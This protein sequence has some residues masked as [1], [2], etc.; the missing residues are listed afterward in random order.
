MYM[1]MEMLYVFLSVKQ[2]HLH[3]I[4]EWQNEDD[5]LEKVYKLGSRVISRRNINFCGF[6]YVRPNKLGF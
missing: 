1:V 2:T 4:R 6:S 5:A 3:K